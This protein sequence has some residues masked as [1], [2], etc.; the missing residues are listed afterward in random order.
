MIVVVAISVILVA[1]AIPI[2]NTTTTN[3]HLGSTSTSLSS[4][5]LS[6]HYLAI[7]SGC[8]VQVSVSAQTYQLSGESVTGTPPACSTTYS[9]VCQG[10]NYTATACPV[11]YANSDVSCTNC[12]P[13]Q[14]VQFNSSGT[15]TAAAGTVP[16]SFALV[17]APSSG[18]ATKTVNI[19]GMGYVKVQ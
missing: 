12:S 3:L 1:V 10:T 14:V 17:I 5:L 15:V 13:A 7:S 11:T 16:T 9:Y 18:T 6:A 4:A 2:A 19:S 8:P